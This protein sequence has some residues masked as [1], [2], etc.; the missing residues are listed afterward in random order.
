VQR[1]QFADG[2]VWDVDAIKA[3]LFAGTFEA[4]TI[5]G[6]TGS[7]T[8]SGGGGND[9]ISGLEG[10]DIYIFGPGADADT[11][12]D[13]DSTAG[14]TDVLSVGAG[15]AADQLW[16]RR[17]GASLEVSIIGTGDKSTISNWYSSNTYH[18]EQFK[19]ADG[20]VLTDAKVQALVDAM[21]A[22]SPPAAGQ[23][24]LPSSYQAELTPVIAA[25]W[26]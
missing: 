1:F 19:T 5:S 10:N 4:D 13:Y 24:T 14:N 22:F 8:I 18:I 11:I 17:V 20:K 26:Q 3:K 16:F 7:D 2:T 9:S 25:N 12:S 21:A 23:T 15:V 6:T